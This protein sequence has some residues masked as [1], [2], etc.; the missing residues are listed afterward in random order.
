LVVDVQFVYPAKA[1]C[2]AGVPARSVPLIPIT[3]M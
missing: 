3:G 2:C 1:G